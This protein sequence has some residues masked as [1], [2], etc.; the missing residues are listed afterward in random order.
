M[1]PLLCCAL[2]LVWLSTAAWALSHIFDVREAT[3]TSVHDALFT[4]S[5][6]CRNIV[7]SF[8]ARIEELN[9]SI[10]AVISLNPLALS[11][12]DHLDQRL[13]AG[14]VTGALFC[15]TVLLKDN[16]DAVGMSTTG[17]CRGLAHNK[18]QA[19][20]PSVRALVDA[21]A[22]VL[23]K[24]NLHEM[25]F[26]GLTVSSLGGQT[27]NPYDLTRTPGGSSGGSGA[28]VAASFAVLATGTDTVNSLRSPAS[29]NSLFSFR[30]TR[31]L[32]SRAGVIPVSSTQD[33]V[34]AMARNPSDLAVALSVMASVGFDP[35]DNVTALAP[36]QVPPQDYSAS[37]YRG[38][39]SGL[40]LGLLDGF[41]D[42]TTSIETMPVNNIMASMVSKLTET[43][44][45]IINITDP[46]YDT[47]AIAKLDVQA[48]EFKDLLNAYLTPTTANQVSRG[49]EVLRPT[50]FDELYN[51]D[52]GTGT[53]NFLVIPA[54]HHFIK[55]ASY[56]STRDAPYLETLNR[57]QDLTRA[58]ETTFTANNL[59]A[60]IY[61][62]Q[63]NLVVKIGSP[64]QSG[65][66]G[67][68]AALTGHPVVCVPVG[69]S[70]PSEHAPVGVPIGMEILGRPWSE[71]LL[72]NIASHINE[73]A[74]VRKMPPFVNGTVE[75]KAY[76]SVPSL[77]PNVA[78]IHTAY[79]LGVF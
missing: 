74:P 58:L 26:E 59:D 41:F 14:N 10:N 57:I 5:A 47:L 78:N 15:V 2:V 67:I 61:P 20:A 28:A 49:H 16:F 68:L 64:S 37:L 53:T 44:V 69:F 71:G 65:R 29:A 40:R 38:N 12:A 1:Q 32:I 8:I 3:I 11:I 79:P 75:P 34:G 76:E 72:L 50:S 25:A 60:I 35:R 46:I 30:P 27:V 22:V 55:K 9:P 43:G 39:L 52:T 36:R 6:T 23:G 62:E 45:E 17:G 77:T 42:H 33:T 48:F 24:T 7:S 73:L 51:T 56:S 31:G 4:H 21:G 63:K 54:Q 19:D 70:A 18:P 66:N 13:A